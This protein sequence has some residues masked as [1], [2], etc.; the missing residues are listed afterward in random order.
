MRSSTLTW[1]RA[2]LHW[3]PWNRLPREIVDLPL[4]RYSKVTWMRS[5]VACSRWPYL[6]TDVELDDLQIL[7]TLTILWFCDQVLRHG[8]PSWAVWW[9][10]SAV[11]KGLS[12]FWPSSNLLSCIL[13]HC[14]L[15]HWALVDFQEEVFFFMPFHIC[16]MFS[17][18]LIYASVVGAQILVQLLLWLCWLVVGFGVRAS[19]PVSLLLSQKMKTL[20]PYNCI[21]KWY[22]FRSRQ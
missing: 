3:E 14:D 21:L 12:N 8:W 7:P 5:S 1:R 13:L 15:F 4:C 22:H 11:S 9:L 17:I 2:F 20:C 6:G 16:L 18:L 19:S 10:W